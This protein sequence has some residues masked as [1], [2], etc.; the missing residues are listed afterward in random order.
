M[1]NKTWVSSLGESR[2]VSELIRQGY[3][4]F[5][6][7]SGKSSIDLIAY[8]ENI[9]SRVQVKATSTRTKANTGWSVQIKQVRPN[10][11]SNKIKKFDSTTCDIL[12]IYIQP[13]DKVVLMKSS[14]IK[15]TSALTILDG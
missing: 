8:K 15:V 3:E 11:K 7:L 12:A 5:T 6:Q 10:R 1:D 4:V 14:E 2:V 13:L 9:L